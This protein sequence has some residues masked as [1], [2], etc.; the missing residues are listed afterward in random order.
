MN[1]EM[2]KVTI[3]FMPLT[4]CLPLLIAKH[5]QFFA[6]HGLDVVLER[7][8]SWATLRDKLLN[9][10]L[11]AAHLL[12][13]M[14]IAC[15]CEDGG[16]QAAIKV[17]QVLSYNGNGITL[18]NTLLQE[19]NAEAYLE[20]KK[21]HRYP[22]SANVLVPAIQA[23]RDK[24]KPK[25]RFATVFHYSNHFYQLRG[26]LQA[27][28][29]SSSEVEI[30]V[31]PPTDMVT[32]MS[33]G[34]IDGFCVGSPWNARAVREGVGTTIITSNDLWPRVPEK[35]LGVAEPWFHQNAT[36]LRAMLT[37]IDQANEWLSSVANRF[38]AARLLSLEANL[39]VDID[40]VTPAL[41]DSCIVNSEEDP[42]RINKYI[43]F[44]DSGN[45]IE[46]L[47]FQAEWL[48]R[49]M[50]DAGHINKDADVK[51]IAEQIYISG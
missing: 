3:G 33:S 30:V 16:V 4:D 49:Q 46:T 6:Q 36:T 12:A 5:K 38:E 29:I 15:Y 24:R 35:V 51:M 26:W 48:M 17:P 39:N 19:T 11:D 32:A 27:A 31:V 22:F 41:L 50:I 44:G 13:P 43:D 42:R 23:R 25:L 40:V 7:Q 18:S 10:F 14:P 1:H 2:T 47:R 20:S 45:E 37:A 8:N 28:G 9:G 21:P 34:L